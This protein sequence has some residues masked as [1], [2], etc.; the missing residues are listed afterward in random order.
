MGCESKYPGSATLA[1]RPSPCP[2]CR[3]RK[4]YRPGLRCR[5]CVTEYQRLHRSNKRPRRE[6]ATNKFAV[7]RRKEIKNLANFYV[8]RQLSHGTSVPPSAWPEGIVRLKRA[9]LLLRRISLYGNT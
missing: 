9:A 1:K 5:Q 2:Q 4:R 6:P 7:L 3:L 8:R